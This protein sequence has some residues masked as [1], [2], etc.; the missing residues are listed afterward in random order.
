M[1]PARKVSPPA[2]PRAPDIAR[3]PTVAAEAM[4]ADAAVVRRARPDDAEALARLAAALGYASSAED[5]RLRLQAA[6]GAVLVAV[7]THDAVRGFAH[8][9]RYAGLLAAVERWALDAGLHD[10]R[11]DS[12]VVRER[13]HHFY[14]RHGYSERKRQCVFVRKLDAVDGLA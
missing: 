3:M 6:A 5:M 7:D 2:P 12:N 9:Q 1:Q 14:L 13:A 8:M 4:T 10:L 11:V